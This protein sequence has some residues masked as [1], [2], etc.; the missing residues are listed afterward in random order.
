MRP[1]GKEARRIYYCLVHS[2]FKGS[3]FA[4]CLGRNATPLPTLEAHYNT[5]E[6]GEDDGVLNTPTL[7]GCGT[8]DATTRSRLILRFPVVGGTAVRVRVRR[9]IEMDV[10]VDVAGAARRVREDMSRRC[11]KTPEGR[12]R[13]IEGCVEFGTRGYLLIERPSPPRP[14]V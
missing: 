10:D 5:E 14:V 6:R 13:A 2:R 3:W 12:L 4:Q 1:H 7:V 8:L 9:P 11:N